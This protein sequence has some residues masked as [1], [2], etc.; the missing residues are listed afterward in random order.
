MDKLIFESMS[1]MDRKQHLSAIADSVEESTYM[2]ELTPEEMIFHKDRFSQ[3]S[4]EKARI[5]DELKDY[6]AEVKDMLKPITA[7]LEESLSA[8]KNRA[9]QQTGKVYKIVDTE[10]KMTGYYTED[11]VLINSRPMTR[12]EQQLTVMS[13]R[14]TGTHD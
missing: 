11:G 9:I 6:K 5:N 1:V 7:D 3:R 10:T 14:R 8:I 12:D 13:V 2:R 4:I